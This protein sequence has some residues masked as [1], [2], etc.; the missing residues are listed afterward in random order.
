MSKKNAVYKDEDY[1]FVLVAHGSDNPLVR[2]SVELTGLMHYCLREEDGKFE[3]FDGLSDEFY[4]VDGWWEGIDVD[5]LNL[6]RHAAYENHGIKVND[7]YFNTINLYADAL[8]N[9][10]VREAMS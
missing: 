1:Y 5:A 3:I 9:E 8:G 6:L 10:L 4:A 7:Y 2:L